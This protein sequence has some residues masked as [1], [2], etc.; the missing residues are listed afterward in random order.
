MARAGP[1][2]PGWLE[3]GR[4]SLL[5]EIQERNTNAIKASPSETPLFCWEMALS[6]L[7]VFCLVSL[8]WQLVALFF[9]PHSCSLPG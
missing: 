1:F 5:R 6:L 3:C 7:T 2:G 9:L 8:H 4:C